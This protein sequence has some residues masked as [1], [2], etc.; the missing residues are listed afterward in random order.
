MRKGWAVVILL[1]VL[2]T[3]AVSCGQYIPEAT[4]PVTTVP[5]TPTIARPDFNFIFKYGVT[6]ITALDT[7]R[8][9][10]TK[11]MV[12]DPSVTV[13]LTL[14]PAEMDSIYQKMV[15]IDFFKY[16]DEFSVTV[17]EGERRAEV[18]PYSTYYF[19]VTY[20]EKTKEVLWHDKLANP[21][22]MA[23]KLRG[24]IKLILNIIESKEEYKQLPTAN[25]GYI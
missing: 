23:D 9:T 11:D 6:G 7:Y 5:D 16:P 1:A 2:A 20:G 13:N 3:G 8:G 21:D 4:L 19:Q 12:K 14:T 25:G 24:L 10:Y 22:D 15:E 18:T 17:P